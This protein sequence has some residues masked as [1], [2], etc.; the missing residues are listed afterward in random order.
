MTVKEAI[1]KTDELYPNVFSFP[2]K[3]FFLE[4][5]DAKVCYE[6]LCKYEDGPSSF[7][8]NYLADTSAELLIGKPYEDIYIKYLVMQFDILNSDMG[9][10]QNSSALFNREY[11]DFI[12]FYNRNHR[13]SPVRI[14]SYE[15]GV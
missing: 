7:K 3:V 5:L 11:L 6:F 13:I 1:E 8:G 4:Q 2:Q 15:G 14:S 10:Y 12:C 9:R